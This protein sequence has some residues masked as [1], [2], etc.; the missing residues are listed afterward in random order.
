MARSTAQPPATH[1]GRRKPAKSAGRSATRSGTIH[2]SPAT[3]AALLQDV[4]VGVEDAGEF[5]VVIDRPRRKGV[6]LPGRVLVVTVADRR[7]GPPQVAYLLLVPFV[8]AVVDVAAHFDR[9]G[10]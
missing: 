9:A 10:P 7:M 4:G 5:P 2:R 1:H 8:V 6:H 3:A